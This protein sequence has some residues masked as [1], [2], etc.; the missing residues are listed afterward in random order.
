MGSCEI[1]SWGFYENLLGE[2]NFFL[3]L[4]MLHDDLEITRKVLSSSEMVPSC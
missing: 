1:L 4:G 3:K 2:S